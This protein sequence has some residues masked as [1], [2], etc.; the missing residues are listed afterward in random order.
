MSAEGREKFSDERRRMGRRTIPELIGLLETEVA[1]WKPGLSPDGRW[2]S[3]GLWDRS[4]QVWSG[5]QLG[6]SVQDVTAMRRTATG[7]T[8]VVRAAARSAI[9]AAAALQR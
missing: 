6:A 4:I 5:P 7:T 8:R 1:L 2:I 3:V 9:S